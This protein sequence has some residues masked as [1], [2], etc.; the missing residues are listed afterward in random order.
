MEIDVGGAMPIKRW[1]LFQLGVAVFARPKV[2]SNATF[3]KVNAVAEPDSFLLLRG[4]AKFVSK[5]DL[6]NWPVPLSPQIFQRLLHHHVC[7]RTKCVMH[8]PHS[9]MNRLVNLAV[10]YGSEKKKMDR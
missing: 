6:L 8:Q 9:I 7:S 5:L 10:I 3:H 2:R 1:F 4:S